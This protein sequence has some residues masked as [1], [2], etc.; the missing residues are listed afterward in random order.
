MLELC[1]SASHGGSA[2]NSP[3]GHA[4]TIWATCQALYLIAAAAAD[5]T[6][7]DD[8]SQAQSGGP[9]EAAVQPEAGAPG[10]SVRPL[11]RLCASHTIMRSD[12]Q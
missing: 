6:D 5:V 4:N 3:T 1:V 8:S 11:Q 7:V 2:P 9:G 10:L 12:V